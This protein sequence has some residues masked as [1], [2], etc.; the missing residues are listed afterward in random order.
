[1]IKVIFEN[2]PMCDYDKINN[3]LTFKKSI[4]LRKIHS[5]IINYED[6]PQSILFGDIELIIDG[7]YSDALVMVEKDN[8][9]IK[10]FYIV[11]ENKCYKIS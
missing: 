8:K 10:Y 3:I 2:E 6:Y 11:D 1:M 5:D 7:V 9:D 4:S